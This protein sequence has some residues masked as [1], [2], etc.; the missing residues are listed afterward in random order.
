MRVSHARSDGDAPVLSVLTEAEKSAVLDE[1]IGAD[2]RLRDSA[3]SAA[4]RLLADVDP[5]DVGDALVEV[6]T[7]LDQQALAARAGPT[8]HGYV[9]PTEAAWALLEEALAPWVND[10]ARLARVSLKQAA[11]QTGLL[12]LAGLQ[13]CLQHTRHDDRL[14]SWAPD[15]PAEAA[16]EVLRALDDNAIELVRRRAGTDRARLVVGR[17][18]ARS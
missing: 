7:G 2:E 9:E 1:L 17:R 3:E 15:F 8:R 4:R 6:L 14:L 18:H 16:A 5:A 12:V 11:R 13:H 10:L